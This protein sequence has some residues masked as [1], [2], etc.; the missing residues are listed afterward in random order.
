MGANAG[1]GGASA[2]CYPQRADAVGYPRVRGALVANAALAVG[3]ASGW[4]AG[5]QRVGSLGL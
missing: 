2:A 4:I 1:S 5:Y 3:G